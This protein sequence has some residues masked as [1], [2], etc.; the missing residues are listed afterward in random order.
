M[1]WTEFK[2]ASKW[3][4][5]TFDQYTVQGIQFEKLQWIGN[6][7]DT[8]TINLLSS[9]LWPF[10]ENEEQIQIKTK[11]PLSHSSLGTTLP[12]S[13]LIF[14]HRTASLTHTLYLHLQ[15]TLPY[16]LFST[17]LILFLPYTLLYFVTTTLRY[18]SVHLQESCRITNL[19]HNYK[20]IRQNRLRCIKLAN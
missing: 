11:L 14:S 20:L 3:W 9:I 17:P 5:P 13:I 1:P 6:I 16:H 8:V 2:V 7:C 19:I 12:I 18:C 10:T 15:T 4:F